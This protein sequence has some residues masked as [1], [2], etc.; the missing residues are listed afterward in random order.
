MTE[1][2]FKTRLE[3]AFDEF[4]AGNAELVERLQERTEEL[5]EEAEAAGC[6]AELIALIHGAQIVRLQNMIKGSVGEI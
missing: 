3:A 1:A 6:D 2:E 4:I 5:V